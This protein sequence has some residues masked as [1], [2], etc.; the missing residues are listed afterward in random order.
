MAKRDVFDFIKANHLAT[1]ATVDERGNPHAATIEFMVHEDLSLYFTTRIEARKFK[2]LTDKPTVAMTITDESA[3]VTV[4]L[5]GKAERIENFKQEQ[6]LIMELWTLRFNAATWPIPSVQMYQQGATNN[7][8]VIK[9]KPFEMSYSIFKHQ[10]SG[11]YKP[12]FHKIIL[13]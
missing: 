12:F 8:A 13:K 1:L 3:M 10:P 5:T 2:N 9:V 7:I 6:K 4:Q 11:R